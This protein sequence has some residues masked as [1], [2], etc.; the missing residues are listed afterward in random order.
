LWHEA[1]MVEQLAQISLPQAQHVWTWS[2]HTNPVQDRHRLL[3]E[4]QTGLSHTTHSPMP[5]RRH[6]DRPHCAHTKR[7]SEHTT[8]PWSQSAGLAMSFSH[9]GQGG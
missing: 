9:T 7:H 3:H 2:A 6:S 1:Q 5:H 8:W 4:G